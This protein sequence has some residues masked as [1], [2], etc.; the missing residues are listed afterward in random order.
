MAK[1]PEQHQDEQGFVRHAGDARDACGSSFSLLKA[2]GCAGS[3][4]AYAFVSQRNLKI[5]LAF[6]FLAVVLGFALRISEAGWLAVI[7]CIALVMSL[8]VV[9]TAI[10][11][12]VDLVSPEWH[13]LAKRAKDC[14]AGAVY[15]AAFAS[16]AVACVVF[17][18]RIAVFFL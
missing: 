2:F 8:E 15:L 9:N 12:I 16:L 1:K 13:I 10:E 3:G 14:A 5:H 6:A 4:I 17:L 7:I 11:S 18:P